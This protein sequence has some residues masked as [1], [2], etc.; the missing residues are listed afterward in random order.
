M[1]VVVIHPQ[2]LLQDSPGNLH[3]LLHLLKTTSTG[4][5][6]KVIYT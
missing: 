6:K 3:P 2:F 1:L 5:R 4:F